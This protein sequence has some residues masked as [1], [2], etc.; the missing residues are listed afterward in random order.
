MFVYN[1][2]NKKIRKI[3]ATPVNFGEVFQ[4]KTNNDL[5]I[6]GHVSMKA[7]F[8]GRFDKNITW[9]DNYLA[10]LSEREHIISVDNKYI[11]FVLKYN[12]NF[13][14]EKTYKFS[15]RL[16]SGFTNGILKNGRLLLTEI[17]NRDQGI[18]SEINLK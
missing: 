17:K 13:E 4:I 11:Q 9:K 6:A 16:L 8:L 12:E 15:H 14:L 3:L 1:L 10:W 2:E 5:Y 18:I 7:S